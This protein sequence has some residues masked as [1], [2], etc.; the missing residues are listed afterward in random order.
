M[1]QFNQLS[2]QAS[3]TQFGVTSAATGLFSLAG[4]VISGIQRRD[5]MEEAAELAEQAAQLVLE[6]GEIN[7]IQLEKLGE[8][9]AEDERRIT[10]KL[11]GQNLVA[12]A[13]SGTVAGTGSNLDIALMNAVDGELAAMRADFGYRNAAFVE[14]VNAASEAFGLQ[15]GASTARQQGAS[16]LARG[17]ARGTSALNT[18]LNRSGVG[19]AREAR[20]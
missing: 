7:A 12:I 11:F 3:T 19:A 18:Q 6:R 8:V 14:R 16:E 10:R 5:A 15:A 17:V 20:A 2:A 1:A 13:K 9:A 4:E